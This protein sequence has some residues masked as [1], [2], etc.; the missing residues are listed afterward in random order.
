MITSSLRNTTYREDRIRGGRSLGRHPQ[1]KGT[2]SLG[3]KEQESMIN[4]VLRIPHP[5]TQITDDV[6][7]DMIL[8]QITDERKADRCEETL[9]GSYRTTYLSDWNEMTEMMSGD[10]REER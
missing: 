4:Q 10:N 3:P 1:S 8:W 7:P 6:C 5:L 9:R 2:K